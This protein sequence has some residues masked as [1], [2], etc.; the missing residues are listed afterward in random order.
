MNLQGN[1]NQFL[2]MA[3]GVSQGINRMQ[4]KNTEGEI[5]KLNEQQSGLNNQ[6]KGIQGNFK[7]EGNK[8]RDKTTGRYASKDKVKQS[9]SEL[10]SQVE[11]LNL[12][13]DEF[14]KKL[15][16]FK[17]NDIIGGIF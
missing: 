4:I 7:Q 14:K 8:L 2:G 9:I 10:Q 6:I 1:V 15:E 17:K 3:A 5:N 12:Q 16:G 11:A 13:K